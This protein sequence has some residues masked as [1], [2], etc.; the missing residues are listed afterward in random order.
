MDGGAPV[1]AL[2]EGA[3]LNGGA[4]VLP[5]TETGATAEPPPRLTEGGSAG[6]PP[7]RP[8]RVRAGAAASG[9]FFGFL[10]PAGVDIFRTALGVARHES[11]EKIAS[12]GEE[13]RGG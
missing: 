8:R 11:S 2:V 6:E 5:S 1:H 10:S 4:P 3:L 12:S 7:P 13:M 9:A